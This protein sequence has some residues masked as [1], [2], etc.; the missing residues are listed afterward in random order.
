MNWKLN[1][2]E[3]IWN[4]YKYEYHIK[5]ENSAILKITYKFDSDQA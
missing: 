5:M 3:S 4:L 2:F 1:K